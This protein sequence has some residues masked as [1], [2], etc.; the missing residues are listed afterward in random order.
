VRACSVAAESAASACTASSAC[1]SVRPAAAATSP[2]VT[3]KPLAAIAASAA[4]RVAA[5][6]LG[7]SS[8]PVLGTGSPPGSCLPS[9]PPL[10]LPPLSRHALRAGSDGLGGRCRPGAGAR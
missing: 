10:L 6:R 9:L 8:A 3:R 4:L 7:L 1:R 5:G 2:T